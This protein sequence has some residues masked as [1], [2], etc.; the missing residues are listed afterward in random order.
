MRTAPKPVAFPR[1]RAEIDTLKL[2]VQ[3]LLV[4]T[5]TQQAQIGRLIGIVEKY[6]NVL[7]KHEVVYDKQLDIA[8]KHTDAIGVIIA[9]LDDLG[10]R[11]GIR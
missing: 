3:E 5:S 8:G 6:G 10:E 4:L 7:A 11:D 9:R 2:A 1:L